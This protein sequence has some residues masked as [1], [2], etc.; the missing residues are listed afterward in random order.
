MRKGAAKRT[1]QPR[2]Q[3]GTLFIELD[4]FQNGEHGGLSGC[5]GVVEF[6]ERRLLQLEGL[7][8]R[9]AVSGVL[10]LICLGRLKQ[11]LVMLLPAQILVDARFKI[12][13]GDVGQYGGGGFFLAGLPVF[14]GLDFFQ[15]F[16]M[17]RPRFFKKGAGGFQLRERF[18]PPGILAADLFPDGFQAGGDLLDVRRCSGQLFNRPMLFQPFFRCGP[19]ALILGNIVFYLCLGLKILFLFPLDLFISIDRRTKGRS[20]DADLFVRGNG[21]LEIPGI[22][23]LLLQGIGQRLVVLRRLFR[24][25]GKRLRMLFDGR[26]KRCKPGRIFFRRPTLGVMLLQVRLKRGGGFGA[27]ESADLVAHGFFAGKRAAEGDLGFLIEPPIALAPPDQV[28]FLPEAF[29]FFRRFEIGFLCRFECF[30]E[31]RVHVGPGQ[32]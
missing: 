30:P 7:F 24:Q 10:P 27:L 18:L 12:L 1:G 31:R 9:Q 4:F 14:K 28:F 13:R 23:R 25:P 29:K 8:D 6:D 26:G 5:V 16:G 17:H 32:L 19:L 11:L 3:L 2:R 21:R 20:G 15:A 22:R